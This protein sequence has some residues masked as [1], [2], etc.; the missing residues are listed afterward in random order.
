MKKINLMYKKKSKEPPELP[1]FE[2]DSFPNFMR[3]EIFIQG[4]LINSFLSD[5]IKAQKINLNYLKIKADKIKRAYIVADIEDYCVALVGAY[6]FEVM[7][8]IPCNAELIS[9]FNC[10][11]PILDKSTLVV[12]VSKSDGE[13]HTKTALERARH[14]GATLVCIFD[15]CP[16]NEHA[17]SLGFK[18]HSNISTAGTTL[19][20]I[21]MTMLALYL[22]DENEVIT[23]M[24]VQ[25]A[26]EMMQ[27]LSQRIKCILEDEYFIKSKAEVLKSP[28]VIFTGSNVDFACAVYAAYLLGNM[29]NANVTAIPA[30]ELK[31]LPVGENARLIA[32]A[33]NKDFCNIL[34]RYTRCDSMVIPANIMQNG[35]NFV[36]PDSIPLLNPILS[37]VCI[38]LAVYNIGIENDIEIK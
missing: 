7:A 37:G 31:V 33:S 21:A 15:F 4:E 38:Q 18:S 26:V 28:N 8:D 22:G 12:I 29:T 30:G 27:S 36:Y 6:N 16:Q 14:S 17:I 34:S 23:P 5:Y 13:Y 19:R 35:D 25:I 3:K 24:Y 11:N 10:S 9:E 32:F 20:H 2:K 1:A